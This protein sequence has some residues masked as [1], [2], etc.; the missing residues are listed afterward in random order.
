MNWDGVFGL[1]CVVCFLDLLIGGRFWE[2]IG[3]HGTLHAVFE[4]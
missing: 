2:L 3:V 4:F 1:F